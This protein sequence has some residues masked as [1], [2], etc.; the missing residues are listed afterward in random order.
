MIV[1]LKD[2]VAQMVR[3]GNG[4]ARCFRHHNTVIV[5]ILWGSKGSVLMDPGGWWANTAAA[6]WFSCALLSLYTA[7]SRHPVVLHHSATLCFLASVSL[8]LSPQDEHTL[9]LS[10]YFGGDLKTASFRSSE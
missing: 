3:E 1:E 2:Q 4:R 10:R 5:T 9:K 8:V 7:K 6:P